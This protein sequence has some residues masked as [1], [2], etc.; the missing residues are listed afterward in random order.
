MK[1]ALFVF[2]AV[3]GLG[4]QAETPTPACQNQRQCEAMWSAAQVAISVATGMPT[5]VVEEAR[6]ETHSAT[7]DS[8][9][10]GVVTKVPTGQEGYRFI[11][12]LACYRSTQCDDLARSG[13]ELFNTLVIEAGAS[14]GPLPEATTIDRKA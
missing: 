5:R 8:R 3:L 11:V 12:D 10:T 1:A 9:L 4:V 7:N 13:T 14:L 2:G 6:I